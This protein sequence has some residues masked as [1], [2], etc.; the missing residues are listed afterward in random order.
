MCPANH[1]F[2]VV[3][4]IIIENEAQGIKTIVLEKDGKGLGVIGP[5]DFFGE[6]AALLPP[7]LAVYRRRYRTA[8]ATATTHL[9]MLTHD[10]LMDLC[11]QRSEIAEVLVPY[12]NAI[13]E[14]LPPRP[15]NRTPS[16]VQL[17]DSPSR[18]ASPLPSPTRAPEQDGPVI[19]MHD[20]HPALRLV[21]PQLA[22]VE[23]RLDEMDER[24]R[25]I[26]SKLDKVLA[27]LSGR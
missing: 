27:S 14:R 24:Q 11:K 18:T 3:L 9:G 26:E 5:G 6:L 13:T 1:H 23:E 20:V 2:A 16:E 17:G 8:F 12:I 10:D 21:V 22:R 7:S 25:S 15:L 19:S 4:D